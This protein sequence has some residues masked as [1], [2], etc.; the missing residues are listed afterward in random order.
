[1]SLV[2]ACYLTYIS[3][4][5]GYLAIMKQAPPLACLTVYSMVELELPYAVLSLAGAGLF[6]WARGYS[7]K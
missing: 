1:M 2:A 6:M 5:F 3:N 4:T 7:Y